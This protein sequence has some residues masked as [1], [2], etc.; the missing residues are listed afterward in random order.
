MLAT[1]QLLV[2]IDLQSM[3]KHSMEGKGYQQPF[4]FWVKSTL[5]VV[6]NNSCPSK[7]EILLSTHMNDY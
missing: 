2:A 1:K 4:H 3:R 7:M 5:S 6:L